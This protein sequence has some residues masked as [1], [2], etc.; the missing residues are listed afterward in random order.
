MRFE[1]EQL[2]ARRLMSAGDLDPN[3]GVGGKLVEIAIQP[4]LPRN[5]EGGWPFY[6]EIATLPDDKR[7]VLIEHQDNE[8]LEI[9]R[10][11]PNA[12][13]DTTFGVNGF[14]RIDAD[15]LGFAGYSAGNIDVPLMADDKILVAAIW[16]EEVFDYHLVLYRLNADGSFDS[17]FDQD[18]IFAYNLSVSSIYTGGLT[19]QDGS[20]AVGGTRDITEFFLLRIYP[21]GQI[22][23]LPMPEADRPPVIPEFVGSGVSIVQQPDGKIIT[24]ATDQYNE[25][26]I[27]YRHLPDNTLDPTF[28]ENGM[29]YDPSVPLVSELQVTPN[30]KLLAPSYL[31]GEF[32]FIRCNSDGSRE[33]T[34]DPDNQPDSLGFTDFAVQKDEKIVYV[35]FPDFAIRRLNADGTPDTTFGENGVANLDFGGID[36]AYQI[37]IDAFG[38]IVVSGETSNGAG[39]TTDWVVTRLNP[40]GSLDT[41]F[42]DDGF[43]TIDFCGDEDTISITCA[44]G[45][46]TT[47]PFTSR[48]GLTGIGSAHNCSAMSRAR[49]ISLR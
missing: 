15:S 14:T 36:H 33:T 32:R 11:H 40:D 6:S 31:S 19:L 4:D 29:A 20:L 43:T 35:H 48:R 47:K 27:L 22:V 3:Y 46:M 13:V 7:I 49:R 8:Y 38:R 25:T 12:T 39:G 24:L 18:G 10:Y 1:L 41:S 16:H 17:T 34:L 45:S 21:D 30:G 42:S 5:P 9:A 2:E 23:E 26:T 28:G 37:E 44:C